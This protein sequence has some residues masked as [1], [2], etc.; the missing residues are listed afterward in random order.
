MAW[1]TETVELDPDH[2]S[3]RIDELLETPYGDR[4]VRRILDR[5]KSIRLN[6]KQA[7]AFLEASSGVQEGIPK[8]F[9]QMDIDQREVARQLIEDGKADSVFGMWKRGTP[10]GD[11]RNWSFYDKLDHVD[12]VRMLFELDGGTQADV[13]FR[14][15][16]VLDVTR[17]QL[18]E[19]AHEFGREDLL[20]AYP[21]K[22]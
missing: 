6:K 22:T 17:D 2:V 15:E 4:W 3:Q 16:D 20:E 21:R 19:M 12:F 5:D 8:Y 13:A 1:L 14:Y 18:E 7:Q 9:P 11:M 10:R